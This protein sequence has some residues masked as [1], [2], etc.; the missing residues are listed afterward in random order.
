MSSLMALTKNIVNTYFLNYHCLVFFSQSPANFDLNLPQVPILAINLDNLDNIKNIFNYAGCQGFFLQVNQPVAVFRAIEQQIKV[1][2]DRFNQRKYVFFATEN[3]SKEVFQIFETLEANFVSDL[4]VI[5][6]NSFLNESS[7]VFDIWTH[8]YTGRTGNNKPFLLDKWFAENA[9]FLHN[10]NLFPNKLGNQEGRILKLAVFPYE[11]YVVIEPRGIDSYSYMGSEMK[12]LETFSQYVNASISPVI[13]QAD[14]WGEIWNNWSGSGLMGNLVE[15]KADIGAAALYTWEFAYEYLDLS[16]PTVRTGITCL[17]PAPKLSA[18]WL[19]PF[20]VYS[21][22]AWMALIGTLALSFL[23]L[24]ALNKLQISVKPQL[25]SKHHI[26]Q[27]K[28]KLLSKTLMSVSKPFVMQ[29]ITNKEM[30]QGNLAKYLMGLV[31]LSTLVLSTT[32][33]SGLATIMTVPRYDNPINTI[34]ELAESGLP[35]GGTQDAWILSINNSLEPNLMKLVARF[36]AHSEANLRKY[37]LGDQFAFGVE[38]LPNDNY[39]IGAYIKEDVIQNYHLMTHDIYW[40]MCVVMMRKSSVLLTEVD[41]FVLRVFEA[42]LISYWQNEAATQYM[43]RTVQT[44][45][46]YYSYNK[47]K[48]IVKLK[49]FHVQGAFAILVVGSIISIAFFCAELAYYK[50]ISSAHSPVIH[51]GDYVLYTRDHK[52]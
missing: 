14:Y 41:K 38:R 17:V 31:F 39:A 11:P 6:A 36:V 45:V 18:G 34:E 32:F 19:T 7:Q 9:S 35:W 40:E 26:N 51:L 46:R 12:I 2:P 43:D 44:A 3:W 10:N 33:D 30:A 50:L 22:E 4:T 20:R 24:Y 48:D 21:L 49:M 23:A 37:S 42:G 15:D 16:K 28:G 25:K 52:F 8:K 1:H 13:N 27:L 29:S 5:F 47:R